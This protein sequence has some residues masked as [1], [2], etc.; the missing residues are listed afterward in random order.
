MWC[1][2]FNSFPDEDSIESNSYPINPPSSR[3]KI[4]SLPQDGELYASSRILE[5]AFT[6]YGDI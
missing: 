4:L 6:V 2:D 5:L 1:K 3:L